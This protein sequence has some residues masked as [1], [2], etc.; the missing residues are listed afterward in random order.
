MRLLKKNNGT[1]LSLLLFAPPSF[2][3]PL[4]DLCVLCVKAVLLFRAGFAVPSHRMSG[5]TTSIF[6]SKYSANR[7]SIRE[8]SLRSPARTDSSVG[9]W[10][11][12]SRRMAGRCARSSGATSTAAASIDWSPAWMPS[13]MR[14]APR[15]RR[16]A[17]G[18]VESNVQLTQRVIDAARRG[19]ARRLVFISSQA[20]AGP[21]LAVDRPVSE[22]M[23]PSPIE[24]YGRTKLEAEGLVRAAADLPSVIVR[25]GAVYGPFDRDFLAMFR[26][27]MR[28][29]AIHAA[30][31][32]QW[33]SIAHAD[34]V[35]AGVVLACTRPEAVGLTFF[36]ANDEPVQWRDLFAVAA[37]G[38]GR[39]LRADIE[40]PAW[41]VRG[42]ALVGDV[43][44][45]VTG[46]APLLTSGKVALTA[47]AFG[48]ARASGFGARSAIARRRRYPMG[49]LRH[50]AGIAHTAGFESMTMRRC[51]P[52]ML[53]FAL[54]P[55][56]GGTGHTHRPPG[57]TCLSRYRATWRASVSSTRWCSA[58]GHSADERS[59]GCCWKLARIWTG[60]PLQ[61][62][63][64]SKSF[65]RT[66]RAGA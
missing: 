23:T 16:H 35:A 41:L 45:R 53:W 25:P 49:S 39:R 28:G 36:V 55:V 11:A 22:D 31:R 33:I 32:D 66:S 13:F 34:D 50:C 8:C 26:L 59:R 38:A 56:A 43:V 65:K 21:A 6:P 51:L 47:P 14:R 46:R 20:A 12:G 63:G 37:K 9:T 24:D 10:S 54:A 2:S 15:V 58:F 29:V 60:D 61:T 18:L 17:R 19:G 57:R 48:F 3:A 27:A 1:G 62:N 52:I 30:N 42:G 5:A 64:R 40:V 4:R 44:S 7:Q